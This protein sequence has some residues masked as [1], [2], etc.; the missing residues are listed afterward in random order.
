ME[1]NRCT[2]CVLPETHETI[3]FDQSGVCNVC[4][5]HEYKIE[6]IDWPSKKLELDSLIESYR[7]E[8]DYDCI[9]PY[10]GGKDSTWT[11][12]YLVKT[13]GVKPLVVRFDHGFLR[14]RLHENTTRVLR[15]LGVDFHTFTPNW[16]VVQK[17]MLQSFLEKGDFCWHCHAGIF[18]YP[19]WVA[20]RYNVPLVVWGEPSSEYTSYYSY[21]QA[22]EVD[23]K[24]F[25]RY[26]NLGITAQDMYVRL[27]GAVDERELKP[28]SYPALKELRRINYR[29]V[30]LGSYVPWDVKT[31]SQIIM[32]ELG[33]QGDEVENVPEGYSYEKIECYLQGVRDYIKYIKRGYTRPSHLAS[34]DIRNG[35]LT[36]E[37]AIRVVKEAEDMRPPSLDLFLKYVGLTEEEFMEI[38]MSH[39]VSPYRHDP[40][41]TR[42]GKFLHDYEQWPRDGAM[43]REEAETILDRYRRMHGKRALVDNQER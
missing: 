14:P 11:L 29:S 23:E 2:R 35:R 13:Y 24:R 43:P 9:V 8:Y 22:E 37:E 4:R 25:N 19:M 41:K 12:Y 34:I 7:G 10:S 36:R 26:V 27:Q 38:A 31:Q 28:F 15:R 18:S 40:S 33:W 6:K 16:K 1:L 5:Q 21:E 20:I 32:N 39:M 30:C 42:G 17:L 3:V